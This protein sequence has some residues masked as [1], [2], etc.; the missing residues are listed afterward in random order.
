MGLVL[1]FLALL[2][3][4]HG[5]EGGHDK[6]GPEAG[7]RFR[8]D[9]GEILLGDAQAIGQGAQA[10]TGPFASGIDDECFQHVVGHDGNDVLLDTERRPS[11]EQGTKALFAGSPSA[12]DACPRRRRS[13]RT[14]GPRPRGL[15]GFQA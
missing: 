5:A 8:L 7:A 12:S 14:V 10:G 11:E 9:H 6:E 15:P 4:R 2:A 13:R 3:G 1:A